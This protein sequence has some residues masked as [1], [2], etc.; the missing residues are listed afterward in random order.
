[1]NMLD[2]ESDESVLSELKSS[3]KPWLF[4]WVI[5][6]CRLFFTETSSSLCHLFSEPVVCIDVDMELHEPT[7]QIFETISVIRTSEL[8]YGILKA[9]SCQ[10]AII[11]LPLKFAELYPKILR[12][13]RSLFDEMIFYGPKIEK[14]RSNML[15]R[16]ILK[17]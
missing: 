7:L 10:S 16:A 12:K 5:P 8:S 17:N 3:K 15:I 6:S 9:A 13:C 11:I 1:M 2:I 14:S 4:R